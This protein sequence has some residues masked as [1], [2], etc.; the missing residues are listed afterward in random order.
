MA[1]EVQR[2]ADRA[3]FKAEGMPE[4]A[5]KSPRVHLIWATP[6][7]L[8]AAA[9]MNAI[10]EGRVRRS[11][12]EVTRAE[13]EQVLSDMQKTVLKVPMENIQFHFLLEGVTRG[14]THQL[15]RQRHASFAQESTRF[16]VFGQDGADIP[17]GLPPSLHGTVPVKDWWDTNGALAPPDNEQMARGVWDTALF[18]IQKAYE[19]LIESGM[20]AEDARGLLPTNLLTRVHWVVNLRALHAYAGLR[21]STQAQFEWR[22]VFAGIIAAIRDYSPGEQLAQEL[23]KQSVPGDPEREKA[24]KYIE[25][26]AKSQTEWQWEGIANLFRPVCYYTG[27]CE[28]MGKADR[29]C[30]IRDRVEANHSIGRPSSEW[31]RSWIGN[32]EIVETRDGVGL[33]AE[34]HA[35]KIQAIHPGEWLTDPKAARS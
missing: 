25:G 27:K 13:R 7:P 19:A 12:A 17:V 8:G 35:S 3:M 21:L 28:F 11:L 34:G 30:S 29:A 33:D 10:Y 6:D 22:T 2:W 32:G 1:G 26:F 20:P 24:A 9:A 14:F 31:S 23:L 16:A 5:A 18:E 4:E 15:V